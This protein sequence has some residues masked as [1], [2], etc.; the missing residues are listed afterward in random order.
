VSVVASRPRPRATVIEPPRG[1]VP[2]QLNELWEYRDLFAFLVW[3]DIKVRW[4]Q[5]K[6]GGAWL[7][8]QPLAMLGVYTFAFSRIVNT[9]V[10]MPYPLFALAGLT[11][12]QFTSRSLSNGAESLVS[13]LNVIKRT[14]CPRILFPLAAV[15]SGCVDF[16]ITL[17][18]YLVMAGLYGRAPTWRVVFVLPLLL[19]AFGLAFGFA[20]LLA[21]AHARY[22]DVGRLLPFVIQL[23]FFLS[24]V[25][26]ALPRFGSRSHLVETLNP[27][28]GI[29]GGFRW[30]LLGVRPELQALL[31]AICLSALAVGVGIFSFNRAQ[32]TIADDL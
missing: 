3:R 21:P 22:R 5:T 13:Q 18:L 25:A 16:G 1:F 31:F 7:V 28:V 15:V 19:L 24:P 32:Q 4:A 12:W 8:L 30:A 17:A 23:W 29:L 11:A 14:G 26:Y 6:V 10:D 2:L 27:M 20:L 9:R